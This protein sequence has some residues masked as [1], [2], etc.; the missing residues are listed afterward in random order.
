[1]SIIQIVGNLAFVLVACS[2]MVKDM[3]WLRALSV[4]ASL[5]S[6]VYNAKIATSPLMVPISWNL[7]FIALNFY[8]MGRIIYGN[9]K[10]RLNDKEQE[11]YH[12]SFQTL[13]LQEYAKLLA[14]AKWKTFKPGEVIVT[15]NQPMDELMMIYS[16]SVDILVKERKMN[17]LKDGQF[18]GEMSFLSDKNASAKVVAAFDTDLIVWKQKD[19]KDL[20]AK[21]PSLIF[22][23]QSAMARQLTGILASK[24]LEKL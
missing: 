22:S 17:E 19:L 14:L 15:E 24:N 3:L 13:N 11:L 2:F 6:I 7:F 16:G 10:I 4:T 20:K 8:H 9:R 21:N 23:L 5:C 12:M 1:M 18:I